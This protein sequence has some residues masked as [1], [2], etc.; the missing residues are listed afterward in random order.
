MERRDLPFRLRC[1]V[2]LRASEKRIL[3]N[4]SQLAE[5]ERKTLELQLDNLTDGSNVVGALANGTTNIS[6]LGNESV[7]QNLESKM[8]LSTAI[9]ESRQ[10]PTSDNSAG[11]DENTTSSLKSDGLVTKQTDGQISNLQSNCDSENNETTD[12][13]H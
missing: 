4:A 13:S 12:S 1:V 11:D 6:E 10:S 3:K 2:V 7:E 5:Q 8:V 9:L